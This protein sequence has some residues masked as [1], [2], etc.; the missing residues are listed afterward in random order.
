MTDA[1]ATPRRALR[2]GTFELDVASR[3][4]RNHGLRVTLAD[5]PFDILTALLE[6]PGEIVT[7]EALRQRIWAADTFVDFEH[8]LNAAVHRLR[9][10][11][12][13][14]ADVPRY[15]ETVPRRGYRFIAPVF[16]GDVAVAT[17]EPAARA[18]ALDERGVSQSRL[19]PVSTRGRLTVFGGSVVLAGLIASGVV[20]LAYGRGGTAVPSRSDLTPEGLAPS[21]MPLTSMSGT[22]MFPT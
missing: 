17:A 21:V 16:A 2:F 12:G 1:I 15:V 4:L 3:E 10:A 11:L 6:H 18:G 14:S 19:M 20:Y 5:Q 13:D 7:R 22:E 9:E 8:G